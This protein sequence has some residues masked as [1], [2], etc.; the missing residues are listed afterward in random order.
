MASVRTLIAVAVIRGWLLFQLYV[1]NA[2]LNGDLHEEI[3]AASTWSIYS[4][5]YGFPALYSMTQWTKPHACL[6]VFLLPLI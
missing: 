6:Y 4:I 1:K 3:Y 2:F 5:I